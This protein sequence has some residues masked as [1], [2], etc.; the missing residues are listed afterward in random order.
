MKYDVN[1]ISIT[2]VLGS[3]METKQ[4]SNS[5]V[6]NFNICQN[7]NRKVGEEFVKTPHWFSCQ[8]WNPTGDNIKTLVKGT[9]IFIQGRVETQTWEKDNVKHSKV[10]I[11]AETI[12]ICQKK[13]NKELTDEELKKGFHN[14]EDRAILPQD[15][16]DVPF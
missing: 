9:K 5:S 14:K 11:I 3:D 8:V 12:L 7:S 6:G 13:E 1:S 10:M 15:S 2:G 4:L 16:N